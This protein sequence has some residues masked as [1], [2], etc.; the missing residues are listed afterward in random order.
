MYRQVDFHRKESSDFDATARMRKFLAYVVEETLQGRADRLKADVVA[1]EVLGRDAS[2][3]AHSDPIV[4]IEAGHLLRALDRYY[5][6]AGASDQIIISV[7][8][9]SY[10]QKFEPADGTI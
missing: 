5:L 8:K 3:D 7:P 6:T 10:V 4:R 9:G 1:T 2:F